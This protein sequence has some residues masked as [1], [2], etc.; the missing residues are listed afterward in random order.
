VRSPNK[1]NTQTLASFLSPSASNAA[2]AMPP[3][4]NRP[5]RGRK[6]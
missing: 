4:G 3:P 2:A 1:R 5:G 6:R